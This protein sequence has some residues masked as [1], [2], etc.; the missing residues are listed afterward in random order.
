MGD[1][2][3]SPTGIGGGGG[4][5]LVFCG[6]FVGCVDGIDDI[7]CIDGVGCVACAN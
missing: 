6:D 3:V 5:V 4:G 2:R 7:D 1:S